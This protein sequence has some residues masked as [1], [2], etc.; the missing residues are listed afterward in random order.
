MAVFLPNS[1]R[2][3]L[4]FWAVVKLGAA[5]VPFDARAVGRKD[6]VR[7][8][9]GVS[10]STAIFVSHA[11]AADM[12][13]KN[14]A[15][16]IGMIVQKVIVQPGPEEATG[17]TSLDDL[18]PKH[19][20]IDEGHTDPQPANSQG[21]HLARAINGGDDNSNGSS[22]LW[23]ESRMGNILYIIFPSGT[24]SLPKTCPLTNKN[25][26]AAGLAGDAL[27]ALDHADL[28]LQQAP[29]SHSMGISG[30]IH[31]SRNGATVV[32]LLHGLTP[33]PLLQRFLS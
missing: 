2:W 26:W 27:D 13:Q 22:K 9:L 15:L 32:F 8:Y 17:W 31:A 16:D 14:N 30:M 12:L 29:P 21:R 25:L 7:H 10:K 19:T 1:A 6:E 4:L 11:S 23:P 33:R 3:V 20:G 28:V 24:S 18:T 5:L